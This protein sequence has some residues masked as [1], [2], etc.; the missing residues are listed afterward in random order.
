MVQF[1][2]KVTRARADYRPERLKQLQRDATK[3]ISRQIK[4]DLDDITATW[5]TPVDFDIR[6]VS[7]S[8]NLIV[9]IETDSDIFGYVNFGTRPHTIEPKDPDGWLRFRRGYDAKTTPGILQSFPGG[10]SGGFVY[11]K[12]VKHPG[13]EAR[14]F[15][16]R[17][18]EKYKPRFQRAALAALRLW[19]QQSTRPAGR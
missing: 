18:Q 8:R 5:E 16:G 15:T 11:R 6:N 10:K 19:M 2:V 13:T 12:S 14:N 3:V 1:S 7:G 9:R 17:I 4:A